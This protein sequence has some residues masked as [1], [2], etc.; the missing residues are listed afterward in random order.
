MLLLFFAG[1]CLHNEDVVEEKDARKERLRNGEEMQIGEKIKQLRKLSGM[2]Q[3]QLAGK[4]NIS[5]QALSKWEN[6]AGMPDIECVI[7]ISMLFHISLDELLLEEKTD[8]EEQKR[9]ITLEDLTRIN[10]HNRR[11][12]LLLTS[13]ILFLA[14]GVMMA[15]FVWAL[16]CTESSTGYILYRYIATGQYAAA[17]VNYLKLWAP[18]VM[19]AFVGGVLCVYYFIKSRKD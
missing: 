4:L 12:N 7:K 5:R 10:L 1:A 3:E 8:M 14:V 9:Q 15:V 2:T 13:G 11:M 17:P 19:V 16:R 18:S 6:G